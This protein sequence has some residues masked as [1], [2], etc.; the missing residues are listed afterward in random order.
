TNG[1]SGGS[2]FDI[3]VQIADDGV[4]FVCNQVN[5]SSNN[6][7]KIYRYQSITDPN[8]PTLAFNAT[9]TP[10]QR[11]GTSMDIRGS[12]AGTQ[13]L[14]GC[15]LGP[16]GPNALL[17]PPAD[18]T[19][20]TANVIGVTNVIAGGLGQFSDSGLAFGPTNTFWAKSVTAPLRYLRY[21]LTAKTAT[22]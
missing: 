11:Y 13:I 22:I 12:G 2:W 19:N 5:V 20:S 21:D 7:F 16:T 10:S 4:V 15:L 1:I 14:L 8:P 18:G 3:P 6:A 9:L 17:L